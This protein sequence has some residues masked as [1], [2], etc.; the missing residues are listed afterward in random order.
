M[1]TR[2][3]NARRF[4]WDD[5]ERRVAAGEPVAAV[6]RSLGVSATAVRRAV[7]PAFRRRLDAATVAAQR[8]GVPCPTCGGRMAHSNRYR[9]GTCQACAAERRTT[10]V[11]PRELHCHRC[12]QWKPDADFT[13]KASATHRRGRDQEC[14]ACAADRR[15]AARARSAA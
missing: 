3:G 12:D 14:L 7:D 10:S 5:A 2:N 8:R 9:G 11:R 13:R 1:T 6:A 4:D 15:R